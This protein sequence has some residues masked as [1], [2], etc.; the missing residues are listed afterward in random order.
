MEKPKSGRVLLYCTDPET[1]VYRAL[2]KVVKTIFSPEII[3]LT[4]E[5]EAEL[6]KNE[7]GLIID[8]SAIQPAKTH[9]QDAKYKMDRMN[10][11]NPPELRCIDS[12]CWTV[13][14]IAKFIADFYNRKNN[15]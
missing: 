14:D 7:Y 9:E 5:L 12:V 13:R 10:I 1:P 11:V 8:A 6:R 4:S 15:P 2:E 3:T